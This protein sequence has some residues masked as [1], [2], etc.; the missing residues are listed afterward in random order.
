M[1]KKLVE[2]IFFPA[3]A[4]F[5]SPALANIDTPKDT[6]L[7]DGTLS[8]VI[9]NL[10]LWLLG[11]FGFLAIISFVI[12]GVMYLVATGNDDMQKKAKNQMTWSILGVIIGLSGYVVIKAVDSWLKGGRN[13]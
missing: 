1:M 8:K 6:G 13:F 10:M 5:A 7:P 3:V 2:K 12:S 9:E 11:I 4:L